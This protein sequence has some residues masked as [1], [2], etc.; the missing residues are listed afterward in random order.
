MKIET[1]PFAKALEIAADVI[2]R[3]NTIPILG[4]AKVEHRAE[5]DRL[6][7]TGTDLDMIVQASA[8]YRG[9]AFSPFTVAGPKAMA[10]LFRAGGDDLEL[11]DQGNRIRIVS[12]P[13]TGSLNTLPADDFPILGYSTEGMFQTSLGAEQLDM[14]LRVAGAVSTEET[15]YYLNGVYLHHVQDWT[16]KAVATDGHRLYV[17]TL[18]LPDWS[19]KGIGRHSGRDGDEPGG[20]II[21]R[22]FLNLLRLHRPRMNLAAE[23][24]SF[25]GR[26]GPP[27]NDVKDLAPETAKYVGAACRFGL[28]FFNGDTEIQMVTKLIDGTFP[29]YTRVIPH[30]QEG[31]KRILF[32]AA[33]MRRAID[34]ITAGAS[35]RTRA[36]KLTFDPKG[37]CAV[38][39][40]WVD[41]GFEG[42]IEIP[43]TVRDQKEP[44]EVGYNSSY[45]RQICD[46]AGGEDLSITLHD[47]ASPGVLA[48]PGSTDFLTVLMPMRV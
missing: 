14:I 19:G 1:K 8:P 39:C 10:R 6:I 7:V 43:A 30:E 41:L 26:A 21:P 35:E 47:H 18:E 42:K 17:G 2:E 25:A 28:R 29:D 20:V 11:D 22:R 46:V 31:D 38:S 23:I 15:R 32:K 3:R 5:N 44:F 13:M 48:S 9:A 27:P 33:D 37:K 24:Q 34:A 4:S 45:L 40:K 36:V 16:W 12:G